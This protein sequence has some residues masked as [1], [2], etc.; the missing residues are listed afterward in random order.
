MEYTALELRDDILIPDIITVHYFEFTKD[1]SFAGESHNFW[2]FVYVDCGT[3]VAEAGNTSY[4]LKQGNILF[5]QPNEWHS[6]HA[7]GQNASNI[8]VV[9]F[10]SYSPA[11]KRLSGQ[12]LT[13]D[14]AQKTILSNIIQESFL[15]FSSP[16][17][18]P[19]R[20]QFEKK[21]NVPFGTEQLLKLYLTELL[22][23]LIRKQEIPVPIHTKQQSDDKRFYEITYYM[24]QNISKKLIIDDICT[25]TNLSRSTIKQIF[26]KNAG[27]GAIQYF[28]QMKI[29]AAKTYL[30]EGNYNITQISDLL[31][32][33][34][35]HYF[36][37]Q[38]KQICGISPKEY[39]QSIQA[40]ISE[41]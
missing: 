23:L 29:E 10:R 11:L 26:K 38:F 22:L 30:R 41:K 31:G 16:L 37:K 32:Y 1:Y 36:S 27:M 34:N 4:S 12:P 8:V 18:D 14:P 9:T 25:Y 21:K 28:I 17:G 6:L 39:C 20:N 33:D 19:Y 13:I 40:M 5:H 7:N 3:V 35:I 2:E 24:S 15:L